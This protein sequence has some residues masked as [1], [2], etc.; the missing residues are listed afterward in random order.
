MPSR[1]WLASMV[2]APIAF[3]L[4]PPFFF[5]N[6]TAPTEIYTLS[7]HDA[8]PIWGGIQWGAAVDGDRAYFPVSDIRTPDRK[9]T[10]LNSSHEWTSYAVFGVKKKKDGQWKIRLCIDTTE[11]NKATIKDAEPLPN[12][13]IIFDKLGGAV[14]YTIIDIFFFFMIRRPPRSTLFPSTTLF[15]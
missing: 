4:V 1:V 12:F 14:V 10:R 5:F 11:L 9:S 6:D 3:V 8:L 7:L 2:L 15:R 13:I